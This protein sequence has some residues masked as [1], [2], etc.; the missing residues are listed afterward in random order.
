MDSELQDGL[1]STSNKIE[2]YKMDSITRTSNKVENYK[3]DSI[4][5][6]IR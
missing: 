6:R 1:D 3:M 2:K 4:Q 5:H